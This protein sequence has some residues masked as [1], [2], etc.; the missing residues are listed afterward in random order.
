MDTCLYSSTE[1]SC[2]AQTPPSSYFKWHGPS[3]FRLFYLINFGVC[4]A[5]LLATYI[6][7]KIPT[8]MLQWKTPYQ[9]LHGKPPF[10][11][12]FKIF[13]SLCFAT[14]TKPHRDKFD[15]QTHKC[16]FWD[17]IWSKGI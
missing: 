11:D 1:W 12:E 13:G 15:P 6:I 10:Y 3:C 9:L 17:L 14:N 16:I 8:E 5:I 4:E 7:N 2:G